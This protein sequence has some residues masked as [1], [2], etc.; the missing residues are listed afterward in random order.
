MKI[1]KNLTDEDM[2]RGSKETYSFENE[3]LE[4]DSRKK[5][6]RGCGSQK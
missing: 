1:K 3:V 2:F 4:D 5:V 6:F